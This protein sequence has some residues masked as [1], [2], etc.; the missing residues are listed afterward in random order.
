MRTTSSAI[1]FS[2]SA[3]VTEV[4]IVLDDID[5]PVQGLGIDGS[6]FEIDEL[7]QIAVRLH[8]RE[9]IPA[10]MT[11]K[12]LVPPPKSATRIVASWRNRRA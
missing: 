7:F 10:R 2:K 1:Q 6:A 11:E 8:H 12:S 3:R 5:E 9:Q 4:Q